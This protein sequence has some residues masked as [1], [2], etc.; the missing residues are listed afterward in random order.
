MINVVFL[1]CVEMKLELE[2]VVFLEILV[3]FINLN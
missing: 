2:G 1:Y 3:F